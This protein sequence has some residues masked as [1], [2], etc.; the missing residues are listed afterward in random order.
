V[1]GPAQAQ[2]LALDDLL[3]HQLLDRSVLRRHGL[4]SANIVLETDYLPAN[5]FA[6]LT[7]LLLAATFA[8]A[9]AVLA[10]A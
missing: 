1:I 2:L 9:Q 10:D 5:D 3:H 7:K 8:P 4:A 6:K